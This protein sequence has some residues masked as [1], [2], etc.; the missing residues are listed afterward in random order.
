MS[1]RLLVQLL[2]H[3]LPDHRMRAGSAQ[4]LVR[5]AYLATVAEQE[6]EHRPPA[7]FA[8]AWRASLIGLLAQQS[9]GPPGRA[10]VTISGSD[11]DQAWRLYQLACRARQ[12]AIERA[13]P[14][15]SRRVQRGRGVP[16]FEFAIVSEG[17][18]LGDVTYG[19]CQS[20]GAGMLYQIEF[21]PDW[22]FCGFGRL[23]LSQLEARHPGLTW[24]TTGQFP[25]ARGFY[26]H[27]RQGS[28]SPWTEEQQPCPH[29]D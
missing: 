5:K 27:Y 18:P 2:W 3:P 22:Q 15:P 1:E 29:F 6:S 16:T 23:A 21:V 4:A 9:A 26:E 7:A 10:P 17:E 8:R 12:N 14:T 25:H 19:I 20:C 24:Y 13:T 11:F 28:A